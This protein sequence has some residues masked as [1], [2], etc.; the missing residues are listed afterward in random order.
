MICGSCRPKV[1][2]CPQCRAVFKGHRLFFAERLLER[3]PVPCMF[4]EEGCEIE[5]IGSRITSHEKECSYREV[6]CPNTEWG[7]RE[8]IKKK[9]LAEHLKDCQ[10]RPVDCPVENC[11]MVIA[12]KHLMRHLV[13]RHKVRQEGRIDLSSLNQILLVILVAS[14]AINLFFMLPF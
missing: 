1:T 12:Q 14:V 7:C 11:S 6:E 13:R 3:V 8:M 2:S 10:Y 9:M 4:S 5:M